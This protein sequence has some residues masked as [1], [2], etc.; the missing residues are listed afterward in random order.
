MSATLRRNPRRQCRPPQ[1]TLGSPIP[2]SI[3]GDTFHEIIDKLG[4]A[5]SN[6]LCTELRQL[7]NRQEGHADHLCIVHIIATLQRQLRN[8]SQT[9]GF[10]YQILIPVPQFHGQLT[11]QGPAYATGNNLTCF[12]IIC[13]NNF[14]GVLDP[15]GS[16]HQTNLPLEI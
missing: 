15:K 14:Q 2:I 16:D 9:S 4:C 1:P 11:R 6:L 13:I 7:V 3:H 10:N 5:E 8:N 12:G